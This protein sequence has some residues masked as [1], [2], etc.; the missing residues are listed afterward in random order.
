MPLGRWMWSRAKAFCLLAVLLALGCA[1]FQSNTVAA[2]RAEKLTR[3]CVKQYKSWQKQE[4]YGAFA[5]SSTGHCGWGSRYTTR[6]G[7]RGAALEECRKSHSGR[8]RIIAEN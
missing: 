6:E 5:A 4:S 1:Y 7:A 3:T 8:C 2:Q